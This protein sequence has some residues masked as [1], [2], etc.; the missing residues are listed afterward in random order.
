M[1]LIHSWRAA[2]FLYDDLVAHWGKPH[3]IWTDNGTK[4]IGSFAWFC[5]GLGIVQHYITVGNSKANRQVEQMS[6]TL[7]DCI[8]CGLTM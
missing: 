3:Y 7:K 4:F 1:P 6:R 8:R 2:K 5:K